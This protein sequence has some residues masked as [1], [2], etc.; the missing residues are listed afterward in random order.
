[1]KKIIDF[2]AEQIGLPFCIGRVIL[3]TW[4]NK[5]GWNDPDPI[6]NDLNNKVEVKQ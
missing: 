2:I 5:Q 3:A 6:I 1:M 4:I